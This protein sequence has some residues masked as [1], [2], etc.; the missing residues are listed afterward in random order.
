MAHVRDPKHKWTMCPRKVR[1]ALGPDG[2]WDRRSPHGPRF[3]LDGSSANKDVNVSMGK[4]RLGLSEEMLPT[5]RDA[6]SV[7]LTPLFLEV[8]RRFIEARDFQFAI[9]YM[10]GRT[11]TSRSRC[12]EAITSIGFSLAIDVPFPETEVYIAY[13]VSPKHI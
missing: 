2:T 3:L 5:S 6:R 12:Q 13:K 4:G 11:L 9:P 1:P 7:P 10:A 8:N